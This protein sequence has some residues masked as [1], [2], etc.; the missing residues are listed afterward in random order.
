LVASRR[1]EVVDHLEPELV[2]VGARA[3][4]GVERDAAA[5]VCSDM[6]AAIW[7]VNRMRAL[8]T[9]WR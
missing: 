6:V 3:G 2:V 8:P 1:I 7:K 4:L 5:P 9:P